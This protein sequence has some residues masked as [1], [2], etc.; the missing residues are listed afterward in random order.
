MMK[1][2]TTKRRRA[3]TLVELLVVLA[4]LSLLATLAV[5]VYVNKTEQARRTTARFEVRSI[6]EAEEQ[7]VLTHGFYVPIHLL[8]N[9]AG[10]VATSQ[11]RDDF[12]NDVQQAS[13]FVINPFANLDDQ[14]G[15]QSSIQDGLD[16]NDTQVRNMLL[17]WAGPFLNPARVAIDPDQG[18]GDQLEVS[19]DIV[20]DPWGQPYL[21][22]SPIGI[23]SNFNG[24][25]DFQ[26]NSFDAAD[27]S[28]R[29]DFD[30]GELQDEPDASRPF[31][32][33]AIIS[34]G[35]DGTLD[36][37]NGTGELVDDVFYR[38]GFSLNESAFNI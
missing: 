3:L 4:I 35:P 9:V 8:D 27:T 38:F 37:R 7:V 32:R 11:I 28:G 19:N 16:S 14:V 25:D 12:G 5:P 20:L 17:N 2:I 15:N 21:L 34:Y 13:K 6:A 31:D 1:A 26:G 30:N 24:L 18:L 10:I 23:V 36:F 22:Y 29:T 33:F